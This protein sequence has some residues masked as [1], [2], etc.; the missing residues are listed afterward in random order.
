MMVRVPVK[1][2]YVGSGSD[3]K[4]ANVVTSSISISLVGAI[5]ASVCLDSHN[6]TCR[7]DK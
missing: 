7:F 1:T 3:V 4:T 2:I 5:A 6:S